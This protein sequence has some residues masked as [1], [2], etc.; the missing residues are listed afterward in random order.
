MSNVKLEVVVTGNAE[1]IVNVHE[2][3]E[4]PDKHYEIISPQKE[5]TVNIINIPTYVTFCVSARA[6]TPCVL[7]IDGKEVI[8]GVTGSNNLFMYGFRII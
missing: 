3:W 5:A 7:K 2:D 4:N 6:G 1:W 8:K